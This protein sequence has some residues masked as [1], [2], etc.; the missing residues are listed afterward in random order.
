MPAMPEMTIPTPDASGF[1]ESINGMVEKFKKILEPIKQWFMEYVWGPIVSFFKTKVAEMQLY[2][3]MYGE[4]FMGGLKAILAFIMPIIAFVASFIW[5]SIKGAID[6]ILLFFKGLMKF[7][8]GI[9][10]GDWNRVWEGLK[11]MIFGALQAI[12]NITNLTF[13][14]RIF[15]VLKLFLKFG[16]EIITGVVKFFMKNFDNFAKNGIKAITSIW[17][18]LRSIFTNAGLWVTRQLLNWGLR[19]YEWGVKAGKAGKTAWEAIQ[20]VFKGAG[21]WF[22][23]SVITPIVNHFA[24]IKNAFKQGFGTGVKY[25]LNRYIDYINSPIKALK[26]FSVAGKKP[27][28]GIPTIPHLAKGGIATGP[29]LALI[30]EGSQDEAVAP[31]DKL[32]GMIA[33]SVLAAM[34]AGGS[35]GGDINLYIDGRQFAR[36]VKPHLERENKRVGANVRLNSI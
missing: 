34:K 23:R 14:G 3:N 33:N 4:D 32:H 16:K 13:V 30:G 28:G 27:F 31:L 11:D 19:F 25:L 1:I 20:K 21:T 12:W 2:W 17:Y 8:G 22:L 18:N 5:E 7:I 6:G 9:F 29:T 24:G 35:N 10:A 15:G 26:G 36:L